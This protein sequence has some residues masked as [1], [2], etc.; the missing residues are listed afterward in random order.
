MFASGGSGLDTQVDAAKRFPHL[1]HSSPWQHFFFFCC[2]CSTSF[3]A[4]SLLPPPRQ[5]SPPNCYFHSHALPDSRESDDGVRESRG[6]YGQ[7]YSSFP[8][9]NS[10][11]RFSHRYRENF[12]FFFSSF[13]SISCSTLPFLRASLK[14]RERDDCYSRGLRIL[15]LA[16]C[17]RSCTGC[18]PCYSFRFVPTSYKGSKATFYGSTLGKKIHCT[19]FYGF[20]EIPEVDPRDSMRRRLKHTSS[21]RLSVYIYT[22]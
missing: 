10:L 7:F 22:P 16:H 20:S 17:S 9:K 14:T 11:T 21:F 19:E 1:T 3:A 12:F 5:V 18:E 8:Q 15:F 4:Y 2:C 6:F 13:R